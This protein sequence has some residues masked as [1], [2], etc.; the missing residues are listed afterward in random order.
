MSNQGHT[1]SLV[2]QTSVVRS[3]KD[4]P[5][6][7]MAVWSDGPP[8]PPYGPGLFMHPIKYIETDY[9]PLEY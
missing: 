6:V 4:F 3:V 2:R 8:T 9:F 7:S 1:C 5:L